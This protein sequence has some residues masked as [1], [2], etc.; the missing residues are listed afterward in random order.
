MIRNGLYSF[1]A[2]A[3]NDGS[4]EIHGVL[5]FLDGA[6]YGGDSYVYYTGTYECTSDRNW[7]GKLTS[8]EHTPTTRPIEVRIQQ[9]GFIGT[10]SGDSAK[11]DAMALNG[12]HSSIRYDATLRLLSAADAREI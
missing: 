4:H 2:L 9:I 3:R 5:I 10:Y 1:N 6:I 7:Q 12:D 8:R 11:V